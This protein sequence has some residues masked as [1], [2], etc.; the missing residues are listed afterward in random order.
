MEE[1]ER[2]LNFIRVYEG[3]YDKY[4]VRDIRI[5]KKYA[6]VTF[7]TQNAPNNIKQYV[8]VN[9]DGFWEVA[10]NNLDR[11]SN[12]YFAVNSI[13]P[14]FNLSLLPPYNVYFYK[15]D[16]K[17][18]FSDV[19]KNMVFYEMIE[20]QSQVRYIC[21][22]T[23]YCY[24]ILYGNERYLGKKINDDWDIKK[25]QSASDAV[26]SMQLDNKNAPTFIVLDE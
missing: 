15:N 20:Q 2:I 25:V 26:Q 13:L 19:L 11:Q 14:D 17:A 22:T 5:D 24:I 10:I 21:G 8:L 12:L 23:N 4:Y 9:K 16:M 7:S 6:V 18:D 3:N 1:Y